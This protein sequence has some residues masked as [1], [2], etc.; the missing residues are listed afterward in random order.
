MTSRRES[1]APAK[2][3]RRA[4]R[5]TKRASKLLLSDAFIAPLPNALRALI[6]KA[7]PMRPAFATIRHLIDAK[8][9]VIQ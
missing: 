3:S 1:T 4:I 2:P 5:R 9:E 7:E 6:N 8:P